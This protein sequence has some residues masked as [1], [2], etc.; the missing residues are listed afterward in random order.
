MGM[1][2]GMRMMRI[3]RIDEGG[4][5]NCGASAGGE[6]DY[7]QAMHSH[8][9]FLPNSAMYL[10]VYKRVDLGHPDRSAPGAVHN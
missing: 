10:R 8:P 6:E 1:G 9:T 5:D 2:M 7:C 4:N 3:R